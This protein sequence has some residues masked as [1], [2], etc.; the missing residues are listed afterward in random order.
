MVN[1]GFDMYPMHVSVDRLPIE[2]QKRDI[3]NWNIFVIMIFLN[4]ES[5]ISVMFS[6]GFSANQTFEWKKTSN[7]N[8]AIEI[9][10]I[11]WK[12]G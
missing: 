10:K 2:F 7:G 9:G 8:K 3:E 6:I 4:F 5:I 12:C 11:W 1:I